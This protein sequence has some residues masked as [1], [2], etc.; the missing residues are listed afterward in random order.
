MTEEGKKKGGGEGE[1]GFL[2]IFRCGS[3]TRQNK[4]RNI[5]QENNVPP[6]NKYIGGELDVGISRG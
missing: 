3:K 4:K 2:F 6:S 1:N 5:S